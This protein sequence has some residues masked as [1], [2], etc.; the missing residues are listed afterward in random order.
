MLFHTLINSYLRQ[1]NVEKSLAWSYYCEVRHNCKQLQNAMLCCV[2]IQLK[3]STQLILTSI[4]LSKCLNIH[5]MKSIDI[6]S[7]LKYFSGIKGGR[8]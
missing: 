5:L 4:L 1:R 7:E 8:R 3:V 2:K 6:L